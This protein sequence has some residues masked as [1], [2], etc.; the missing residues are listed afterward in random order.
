[1]SISRVQDLLRSRSGDHTRRVFIWAAWRWPITLPDTRHTHLRIYAKGFSCSKS[2]EPRQGREPYLPWIEIRRERFWFPHGP[3]PCASVPEA[4]RQGGRTHPREPK[5]EWVLHPFLLLV[6]WSSR[7]PWGIRAWSNIKRCVPPSDD[8]GVSAQIANILF[9]M[10]WGECNAPFGD[11][12]SLKTKKPRAVNAP[13][14]CEDEN[15]SEMNFRKSWEKV[16][17]RWGGRVP[18]SKWRR[19]RSDNST[20]PS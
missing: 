12:T 19:S 8:N 16:A 14:P 20:V 2:D 1:V 4:R 11:S 5:L 9:R 10:A 13:N 17:S 6:R 15:R 3:N 18:E 7:A